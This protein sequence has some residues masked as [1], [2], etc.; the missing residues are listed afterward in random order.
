MADDDGLISG[1]T[2]D[3]LI[4][5]EEM[6]ALVKEVRRADVRAR[7]RVVPSSAPGRGRPRVPP[8]SSLTLR[9]PLPRPPSERAQAIESTVGTNSFMH[10]KV[11]QWTTNVVVR[12]TAPPRPVRENASSSSARPREAVAPNSNVRPSAP[13]RPAPLVLARRR[14]A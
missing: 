10:T 4:T 6:D 11:N 2:E 1:L 12:A 13:N 3:Q 7:S 5:N 8:N 14:D 9:D